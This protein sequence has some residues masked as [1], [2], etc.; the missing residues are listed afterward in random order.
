M[1][2][3]STIKEVLTSQRQIFQHKAKAFQREQIDGF[4]EKYNHLD[5]IIAITGLRRSGKSNFLYL[6]KED[7]KKQEKL[8][9]A[10]W[11]YVN[12]EDTRLID[13]EP[14]DF[15]KIIEAHQELYGVSDRRLYLFLD[16]I[17]EAEAWEKW[18]HVLREYSQYKIYITGSNS[19]LLSSELATALTGRTIEIQLY[20][21]SF[22]EY[23]VNFKGFD[24]CEQ[25][26]Y[27]TKQLEIK[28]YFNNY[29]KYGGMPEYMMN[30]E[31]QLIHNY[32][33]DI[34]ERDIVARYGIRH[35]KNLFELVNFLNT[36]V[37]K[38][39]SLDTIKTLLGHKNLTTVKN[40]IHYLES[41]YLFY[42]VSKFDTSYKKQVYNPDKFYVADI[43]FYNLLAFKMEAN[44]GVGYENIVFNHLKL[45]N[46]EV[47]YYKTKSGHEVDFLVDRKTLI[48]VSYDISNPL[49][50][51]R[52]KRSLIEAMQETKIKNAYIVNIDR[53]DEEKVKEGTIHYVPMWK[54]LLVHKL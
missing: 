25:S 18:L 27:G 30:K 10:D 16:E 21:C 11:L 35:K 3:M 9:D 4:Y 26:L 1:V 50:L 37:S 43:A 6:I 32:Y 52:E 42:A 51:D 2:N 7:L 39:N 13:L 24:L 20:P 54:F 44:L 28:K 15:M 22:R 5:S 31:P 17:Q 33:R 47:F 45:W 8:S 46:K 40:H 38:I 36:N 29:L 48:Q 23:L 49:T 34:I 19:K 14:G 12:F 53:E 41:T